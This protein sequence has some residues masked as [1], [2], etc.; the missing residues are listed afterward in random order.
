MRRVCEWNNKKKRKTL[1]NYEVRDKVFREEL[2]KNS[3]STT[4]FTPCSF[5]KKKMEVCTE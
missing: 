1:Q 2:G 4:K 5:K 3:G